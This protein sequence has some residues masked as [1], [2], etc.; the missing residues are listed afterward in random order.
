MFRFWPS[1]RIRE[2]PPCHRSGLF[3]HHR[4]I[5]VGW[6]AWGQVES[7]VAPGIDHLSRPAYT[8]RIQFVTAHK[9]LRVIFAPEQA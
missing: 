9:G 1:Y 5:A 3:F 6:F 7:L 4:L 2:S 8:S